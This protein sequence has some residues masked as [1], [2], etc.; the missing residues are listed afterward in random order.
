MQSTLYDLEIV[1]QDK[2][3]T[4]AKATEAIAQQQINL[5]GGAT[6]KCGGEGIFHALFKTEKD[7]TSAKTS[8]EKSGFKVRSQTPVIVTEAEDKPGGAAKI[9]RAIADEEVNLNFTYVATNNR[10]VIGSDDPQK[11][12]DAL[13]SPSS[14]GVRR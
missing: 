8:L 12:T 10:V 11:V 14:T 2:P 9:Y 13:R 5:E 3:G 1:L 7:A 6:F 4:L